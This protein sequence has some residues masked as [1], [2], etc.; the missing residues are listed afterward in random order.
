M[1]VIRIRE[2]SWAIEDYTIDL[3]L[4]VNA[5]KYDHYLNRRPTNMPSKEAFMYGMVLQMNEERWC[6]EL[7]AHQWFEEFVTYQ[8]ASSLESHQ[9]AES[10]RKHTL[11]DVMEY[12]DGYLPDKKVSDPYEPHFAVVLDINWEIIDEFYQHHREYV[13]NLTQ[14]YLP[15]MKS[16]LHASDATQ[17]IKES[18]P[19]TH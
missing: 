15:K 14:E 13:A 11:H 1:P 7:C 6:A 12:G 3:E 17:I 2:I 5:D 9:Y 18:I 4:E 10:D 8:L 16:S 19:S